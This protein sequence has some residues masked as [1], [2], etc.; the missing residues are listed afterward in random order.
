MS[1]MATTTDRAAATVVL[2]LSARLRSAGITRRQ[3]AALGV[4]P[5]TVARRM[6]TLAGMVGVRAS[7]L[8]ADAGR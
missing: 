3:V 7:E 2:D 4:S 6:A 8:V 5:S 1:V